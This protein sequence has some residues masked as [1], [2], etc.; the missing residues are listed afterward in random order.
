MWEYALYKLN[1]IRGEISKLSHI[2]IEVRTK[3]APEMKSIFV[4]FFRLDIFYCLTTLLNLSC[5]SEKEF[6]VSPL[7]IYKYITTKHP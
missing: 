7:I 4:F 3:K 6:L 1:E 5:I 2:N